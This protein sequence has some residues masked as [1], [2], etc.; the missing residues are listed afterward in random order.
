LCAPKQKKVEKII[1]DGV[2]VIVNYLETYQIKGESIAFIFK[3]E[4]MINLESENLADWG[5]V[6]TT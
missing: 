5:N 6:E 3:E 1:E 4:F 2:E